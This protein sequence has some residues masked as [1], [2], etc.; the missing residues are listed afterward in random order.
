MS[1]RKDFGEHIRR[2]A[3]A[4]LIADSY[5]YNAHT[6]AVDAIY[7]G[8]PV[9]TMAGDMIQSR[10]AGLNSYMSEI[11]IY[12]GHYYLHETLAVGSG[13]TGGARAWL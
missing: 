8:V 13:G 1:Q 10:L 4:D 9:L 3:A 12:T 7:G 5:T 2:T 11:I 6:T